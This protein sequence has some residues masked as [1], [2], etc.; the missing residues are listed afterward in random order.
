MPALNHIGLW[1]DNLQAAVIQPH[2]NF[3]I[4][5]LIILVAAVYVSHLRVRCYF[6]LS[7]AYSASKNASVLLLIY[8]P[9]NTQVDELSTKGVVFTP[10]GIRKGT[11]LHNIY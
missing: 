9:V 11:S 6:F 4:F 1:V 8:C 3:C 5:D 10:G 7:T 2:Y